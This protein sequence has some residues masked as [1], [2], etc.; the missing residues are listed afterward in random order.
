MSTK[1]LASVCLVAL[2]ASAY[3]QASPAATQ[4]AG[5]AVAAWVGVVSATNVYVR[6]GPGET[7]Y[8]CAQI[9]SPEKV[10][11]VGK[12]EGWLKIQPP[13][14]CFSV[15]RKNYVQADENTKTGLVTTDNIWVRAGGD[16]RSADFWAIQSRTTTG[17]KVEILGS[18]GDY[19]KIV[20]P[21]G[22]F[23]WI[24]ARYVKPAGQAEP[25]EMETAGA[26]ARPAATQPVETV[27]VPQKD[28]LPTTVPT[29][30]PKTGGESATETFRAA[31]KALR[32]EFA[33][34][35]EQR[36]YPAMLARYQGI[37]TTDGRL[38]TYINIR[39]KFI[40]E[41]MNDRNELQAVSEMAKTN[42]QQQKDY[43]A[44]RAEL[45]KQTPP[46]QA[47]RTFAAKGV[48][49]ES[50]VFPGGSVGP[51]R[52]IL[53]DPASGQV[54][55]YVQCASGAVDLS[56]Y[57]GMTIGVFGQKHLD[58]NLVR[59]IVEAEEI[60]VIDAAGKIPAP[61]RPIIRVRPY[62]PAEAPQE[63]KQ[64]AK[65]EQPQTAPAEQPSGEGVPLT[66]QNQPQQQTQEIPKEQTQEQT[67]DQPRETSPQQEQPKSQ[68]QEDEPS[69]SQEQSH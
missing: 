48:L 7:A 67:Q 15:I 46:P 17:D 21:A 53:V 52:Y 42:D 6:S 41:A 49:A 60:V 2:T 32:A 47:I 3:G 54:S 64:P 57:R 1:L 28:K 30:L 29:D 18:A 23:F 35:L 19:Y 13:K 34:P 69:H 39:C 10:N 20:P 63:P 26:A 12:S 38:K 61:P 36:D 45:Q 68:S 58:R 37:S 24:S 59:Y 50:S 65:Q 44:R 62:T 66:S 9:S 51:K 16:L 4:P 22:A 56:Q 8:P 11:V 43:E 27:V 55:A 5:E 14:G 33:K 40:Q 31:E 25:S